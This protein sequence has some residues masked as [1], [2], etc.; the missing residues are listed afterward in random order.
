M[1]EFLYFM[2]RLVFCFLDNLEANKLRSVF[3]ENLL[4]IYQEMES[5][6]MKEVYGLYKAFSFRT[7]WE[8]ENPLPQFQR[9]ASEKAL[10]GRLNGILEL[11]N[12]LRNIQNMENRAVKCF[13][14]NI[15]TTDIQKWSFS[16]QTDSKVRCAK[17]NK[18][19][20]EQEWMRSSLFYTKVIPPKLFLVTVSSCYVV[21]FP[22]GVAWMLSVEDENAYEAS[23]PD[24]NKMFGP[25]L[26]LA[27]NMFSLLCS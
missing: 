27:R 6:F 10:G 22:Y 12:V 9:V 3:M 5:S 14:N 8:T 23:S 17:R 7:L 24:V 1:Q 11:T 13:T 25:F 4:R 21:I 2:L 18:N 26:V 20:I 16:Q 19:Y 15:Y